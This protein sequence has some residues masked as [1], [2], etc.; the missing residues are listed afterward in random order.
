M[1]N[2]IQQLLNVYTKTHEFKTPFFFNQSLKLIDHKGQG[3]QTAI[4]ELHFLSTE[5]NPPLIC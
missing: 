5:P 4:K 2:A 3:D 1:Y